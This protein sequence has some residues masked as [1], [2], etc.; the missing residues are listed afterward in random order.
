MYKDAGNVFSV[1]GSLCDHVKGDAL[2]G[3][4]GIVV[5]EVKN[6]FI[7]W[8]AYLTDLWIKSSFGGLLMILY[9]GGA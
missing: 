9:N 7:L 2:G 8:M 4:R 1:S 6:I 3:D 5:C